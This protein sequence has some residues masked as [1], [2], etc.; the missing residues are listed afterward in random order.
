[1]SLRNLAVSSGSACTFASTAPSHVLMAI[2]VDPQLA[3]ATLRFGFG[4]FTTEEDCDRALK[5]VIEAVRKLRG[6]SQDHKDQSA[7]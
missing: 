1:M 3:Q 7:T 5:M 2:G 4:R 6:A